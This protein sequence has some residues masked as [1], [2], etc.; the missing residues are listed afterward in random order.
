MSSSPQSRTAVERLPGIA[1]LIGQDVGVSDWKLIDQAAVDAFAAVTDDGGPIH[2]DPVAAA[3]IA[4]FGGTILQGFLMLSHLSGFARGVHL[5]QDGIVFRLNYGFDRVRII[6]PA[7]VNSRIRGRFTVADL[8]DKGDNAAL[9]TFN[10]QVEIEGSDS[11]ALV[12][13]WLAFLQLGPDAE[14]EANA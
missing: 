1:A 7:P 3:E 4:P 13:D 10:A 9:L 12:A 14:E 5:P 2:N 11:P 6:T 8:K